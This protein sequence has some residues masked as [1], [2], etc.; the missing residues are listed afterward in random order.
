MD[1][2]KRNNV[3]QLDSE[4]FRRFNMKLL[5]EDKDNLAQKIGQRE[6]IIKVYFVHSK[7]NDQSI[8]KSSNFYEVE[9][10]TSNKTLKSNTLN[11]Q[12]LSLMKDDYIKGELN[13]LY[14]ELKSNQMINDIEDQ[15]KD[16]KLNHSITYDTDLHRGI[17]DTFEKMPTPYATTLN[18][19]NL[20]YK[21]L[22]KTNIAID[23]IN[24]LLETIQDYRSEYKDNSNLINMDLI[25][26]DIEKHTKVDIYYDSWTEMKGLYEKQ[27]DFYKSSLKLGTQ[28]F[29]NDK[30]NLFRD[31]DL[32]VENTKL[33]EYLSKT[34]DTD[35]SNSRLIPL[36]VEANENNPIEKMRN[37]MLV[38]NSL[39]Y[40]EYNLKQMEL[41]NSKVGFQNSKLEEYIDLNKDRAI[42]NVLYQVNEKMNDIYGEKFSLFN[43]ED[44]LSSR[45]KV[46]DKLI[47]IIQK[48]SFRL[49]DLH[50]FE[51]VTKMENS[52]RDFWENKNIEMLLDYK[53][54]KG[55]HFEAKIEDIL[56]KSSDIEKITQK[57]PELTADESKSSAMALGRI[58]ETIEDTREA[59]NELKH[60]LM[61]DIKT[62]MN[63]TNNSND[64]RIENN[65]KTN[66]LFFAESIQNKVETLSN[67]IEVAEN[68]KKQEKE[69]QRE[70]GLER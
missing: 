24:N 61:N 48:D 14:T 36:V 33:A 6:D 34:S 49:H 20:M 44:S 54:S 35:I 16:L 43:E 29:L 57:I 27:A 60:N 11:E 37:N 69:N 12:S 45:A 68:S 19:I 53:D 55:L 65:I 9:L 13:L 26:N 28:D 2:D 66:N 18:D 59:I 1:L 41:Y 8:L 30:T 15:V 70:M 67:Y 64:N 23:K 38:H 50:Q 4:D 56:I 3:Y 25:T 51:P 47:P 17:V 63:S 62:T 58:K 21:E 22:E 42:T 39:E 32:N 31:M 40:M 46:L 52:I 10:D 7:Q 5:N